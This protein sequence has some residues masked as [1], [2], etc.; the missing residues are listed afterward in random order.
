MTVPAHVLWYLS[1]AIGPPSFSAGSL[2]GM[3]F[4][5]CVI[6]SSMEW[7]LSSMP[8]ILASFWRNTG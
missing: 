4:I 7:A 1:K 6:S 2:Y 8:A 5:W 3:T